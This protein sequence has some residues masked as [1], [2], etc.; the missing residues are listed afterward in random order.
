MW[1][2]LFSPTLED[3]MYAHRI[4]PGCL[5]VHLQG[6]RSTMARVVRLFVGLELD[7]SIPRMNWSLWNLHVGHGVFAIGRQLKHF[8][9]ACSGYC[10]RAVTINST[11]DSRVFS[12]YKLFRQRKLTLLVVRFSPSRASS[13]VI[14]SLS[15]HVLDRVQYHIAMG[16]HFEGVCVLHAIPVFLTVD[17]QHTY[18][19]CHFFMLEIHKICGHET[20]PSIYHSTLCHENVFFMRQD[21]QPPPTHWTDYLKSARVVTAM[22]TQGRS[23]RIAVYPNM[24]WGLAEIIVRVDHRNAQIRCFLWA[25]PE[26]FLHSLCSTVGV[27]WCRA[28][29]EE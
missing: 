4:L 28:N 14:S 20:T 24:V 21:T 17:S 9:V 27:S 13:T 11:K 8:A 18:S 6:V 15:R 2:M 16:K 12:T 26:C 25:G 7:D 29:S 5:Y 1:S 22:C 23:M 10:V 19:P 3:Y